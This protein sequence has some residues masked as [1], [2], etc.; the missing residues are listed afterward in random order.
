[1]VRPQVCLPALA[2]RARAGGMRLLAW[3]DDAHTPR[4]AGLG[5]L[6]VFVVSTLAT[7]TVAL[8]LAQRDLQQRLETTLEHR[9]ARIDARLDALGDTLARVARLPE[10]DCRPAVREQLVRIALDAPEVVRLHRLSAT[11]T[12]LCSAFDDSAQAL[13]ARLRP[14]TPGGAF[15]LP[16]RMVQGP[17]A[18]PSL[19]LERPAAQ[20]GYA[21]AQV[22]FERVRDWLDLD[23]TP[24]STRLRLLGIE[25]GTL[26]AGHDEAGASQ[27]MGAF[28]PMFAHHAERDSRHHPFTLRAELDPYEAFVAIARAAVGGLLVATLLAL[29]AVNRVNRSLQARS[30]IG[31]R[32]QLALQRGQFEPYVQ[33]I[34]DAQTGRCVGGE[35]LARWRHPARGMLP[36]GEF[37]AAIARAGL[38]PALTRDLMQQ[39]AVHLADSIRA[40][41]H[42]YLSFNVTVRALDD[43]KRVDEIAALFR[44]AGIYP[45]NVMLEL[46]ESDVLDSQAR[47]VLVELRCKGF[48]IAIDDFGTGESSLARLAS[49]GFDTLKIDREFVRSIDDDVL[50]RPVLVAIIQL[51]RRL[52]LH[53][54]AEGVETARQH[55]FLLAEG[56]GAVQGYLVA[57]PMPQADFPVWLHANAHRPSYG[58][59][60]GGVAAH[61]R[62]GD[63]SPSV[64]SA[65]PRIPRVAAAPR[66]GVGDAVA[67]GF[68]R[69]VQSL[70]PHGFHAI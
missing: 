37:I 25:R 4:M 3:P 24:A 46:L 6:A 27:S 69:T 50:N 11:R 38:L 22:P 9:I 59:D 62:S 8:H 26:L 60:Q 40:Y 70:P 65:V 12:R 68:T 1:M 56:V 64:H 21:V 2:H 20:Q 10:G 44:D 54:I 35:I 30:S 36:P 61:A 28:A 31:R 57:R 66:S 17:E 42:L 63:E 29:L 51:A 55:A 33:P 18:S 43:P 14:S 32:L 52:D 15:R 39:A 45:R 48:R 7:T 53:C 47:Q 19:L 16:M 49:V 41:P 13:H 58:I 5:I 67:A 34:V 23:D